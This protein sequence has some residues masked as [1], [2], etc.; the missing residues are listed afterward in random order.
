MEGQ[1]T[2]SKESRGSNHKCGKDELTGTVRGVRHGGEQGDLGGPDVY[3]YFWR[4]SSNHKPC[5]PRAGVPAWRRS[6]G[7]RPQSA[8]HLP[9][10]ISELVLSWADVYSQ[11]L[12]LH[13]NRKTAEST[14]RTSDPGSIQL[15][16]YPAFCKLAEKGCRTTRTKLQHWGE[17]SFLTKRSPFYQTWCGWADQWADELNPATVDEHMSARFIQFG[18]RRP[19]HPQK[20]QIS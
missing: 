15:L 10:A 7:T 9:L 12:V 2:F 16:A 3:K 17:K 20:N 4:R 14:D 19:S 18:V 11:N 6:S 13:R 5:W 8:P 1:I